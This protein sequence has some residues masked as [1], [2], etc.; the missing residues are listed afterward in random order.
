MLLYIGIFAM[1]IKNFE[2]HKTPPTPAGYGHVI[3]TR[4]HASPSP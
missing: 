4:L 2:N 1:L 3:S